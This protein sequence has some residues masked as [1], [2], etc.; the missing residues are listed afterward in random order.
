MFRFGRTKTP[1]DK[2]FIERFFETMGSD[3][4]RQFHG[5]SGNGPEA[6][7]DYDG[8]DM[9]ALTIA[10]VEKY[11]WWYFC[12][13]LPF[14]T[15]NRKGGWGIQRSH[16]FE[17][18][19]EDYGLLPPLSRREV[20]LALGLKVTRVVTKMG[21]E[22][23]R[24]PFQG[25]P[26]G[27]RWILDNIGAEVTVFVDP[28]SIEEVTVKT[29]DGQTFYF[30]ASLSQFKDFTLQEWVHFLQEWRASDPVS[31]SI[32]V[33]ALHRFYQ[34]IDAE[35]EKLLDFYGKEHKSIKMEDAQT[36][37]DDLAGNDLSILPDNGG[38]S[39]AA[40]EDI[41]GGATEGAGIFM[42]GSSVIEDAEIIE[43]APPAR[44]KTSKPMKKFTGAAKGKGVLK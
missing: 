20:R 41:F 44:Q 31:T 29:P 19:C 43:E 17:R 35:M 13:C 38:S 26:K 5:H 39:A 34:R 33:A 40:P 24:M 27:R 16:L 28:H 3:I 15:T 37:C 4:F 9:T 14:K 21:I 10:Q 7:S 25:D 6:V 36:L 32:S 1:T 23:F 18:L 30:K 42:P 22:A 11:I 8:K 12:D 2:K